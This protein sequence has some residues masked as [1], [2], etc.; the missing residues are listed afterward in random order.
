MD[1]YSVQ[2]ESQRIFRER[3]LADAS[4]GLP[5]SFA[6]A[7][8]KVR[9]VGDDPKPF[10]PTPCKIT[11]SAAALSALVA[12]AAS[13]VAAD[14]YGI[15]YQDVEVNTDLATL[16]LE[17]VLLP[18][19]G[20]KPFL[21]DERL[22]REFKKGDLYE[23]NKP[24]HQEATNVYQT[25]DGR[26]YHLHGSMN[27]AATMGM[28]GVEEQ[29]ATREEAIKIYADK[30]AQWDSDVIEKKSNEELK[31][32]GVVCLTPEEF[33]ASEQGKIMGAEPLWNKKA[34]PAPR[35]QWPQNPTSD[36]KPLAGIRVIDFSRVIAAPVISKVLAV[37]GAEV[38]KVTSDKL[39]DISILWM[40]L[41]TGKKDANLDMKTQEGKDAFAKLVEGADVL[42]DGYRPG[43]LQ[44]L[45]FDSDSLR[46]INSKLIYVRENCYGFKGPLAY[47]SGWQQIS[48]CLVGI[49]WLQGKFMGLD[50]PV[51]PLLPNSD[52][53]TGLI[54][55]AAILQALFQRTKNDATYDIDVSLT[56]YN[57]W[58]Y[59]LGQYTPEQ[60]KALLARNEGFHVRHYDEMQTL[61]VKSHAAITKARPDIFKHPEYFWKMPGNEWGIE[62]D[63]SILAPAFKFDKSK[64]EYT[65]PSGS[66]GRSKP[67]W[68]AS[69]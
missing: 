5:A 62:E 44:R 20:G 57:I 61:L 60:Q 2:E 26:W 11:E 3:V 24:I 50:E 10:V 8:A 54:G 52:Y 45:G 58:Y 17:S 14:R 65:V 13:A 30:V 37:L 40:D 35:S 48:D 31:Q 63:I 43:A 27:A 32:A 69:A 6:A 25:K 19:V 15:D 12:A 9:F 51:V 33:F 22:Q 59:R 39:P 23:M 49:S 46:K 4:L 68:G 16:F 7:A 55:A 18:T 47:R 42:V 36:F 67:E 38:V 64:L 1:G 53:Q 34:L 56:Q 41:S 21:L 29:D 28:V 66:R